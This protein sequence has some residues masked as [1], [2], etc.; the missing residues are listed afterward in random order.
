MSTPPYVA[1]IF[2]VVIDVLLKVNGIPHS[3]GTEFYVLFPKTNEG[4]TND[5]ILSLDL[6]S[7]DE[8]AFVTVEY[9]LLKLSEWDEDIVRK[10]EEYSV[11]KLGMK[12]VF[13][14][15]EVVYPYVTRGLSKYPDSRVHIISSKPIQVLA[16]VYAGSEAGD[17]FAG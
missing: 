7:L 6:L 8:D 13:F 4:D 10:S 12:S 9:Q 2:A 17:S 11:P 5:L 14:G 16:H 15:P 3:A 1:V